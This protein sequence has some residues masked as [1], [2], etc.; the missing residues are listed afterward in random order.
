[1]TKTLLSDV[2][3]VLFEGD[4]MD[5]QGAVNAFMHRADTAECEYLGVEHSAVALP[6]RPLDV[7][8]VVCLTFKDR[9][10]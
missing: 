4:E 3:V 9:S 8:H 1:M 6:G 2:R 10:D 7:V 5:V